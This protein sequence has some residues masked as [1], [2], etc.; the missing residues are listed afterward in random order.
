MSSTA[1]PGSV[2]SSP[3]KWG[4][5]SSS[6]SSLSAS[7]P[8]RSARNSAVAA[9]AAGSEAGLSAE[10]AISSAIAAACQSLGR[11]PGPAEAALVERLEENWFQ[12]AADLA[13]ISDADAA[14]L[15]LPLRL[16]SQVVLLLHRRQQQQQQVSAQA[17]MGQV[18]DVE[19]AGE[20]TAGGAAPD[21]KWT[22]PEA[23][24]LLVS[25]YLS[26]HGHIPLPGTGSGAAVQTGSSSEKQAA[27]AVSSSTSSR[28]NKGRGKLQQAA[29]GGS[30]STEGS[31]GHRHGGGGSSE[32]GEVA[33][34]S[35]VEEEDEEV[36][37]ASVPVEDRRCPPV[38]RMEFAAADAPRLT[39]AG[40]RAPY[41]LKEAEMS[42]ALR[43]EFQ[44]FNRFCTVRFFGQQADP[45]LPV[46]AAKY[47]DHMRL[48]LGW[49]HRYQGQPLATL[50]FSSCLPSAKR[51]G[52][53]VAF[54]YLQWLVSE[55]GIGVRT[56]RMAL[57]AIQQA[58]KFLYHEESKVRAGSGDRA[59][60]DV[61][62]IKEL[63]LLDNTARRQEKVA[64]RRTGL[65]DAQ[66]GVD[67]PVEDPGGLE[68]WVD[69]ALKWLDWLE[70]LAV[71]QEL[72]RECA[73]RD[74]LGRVR[75]PASVA[76]SLQ[77]YLMFAILSCVPD[78]QRTLRELEVGRS[79]VQEKGRWLIRHGPADYK[80]GRA[81]GERPPL[82]IAPHIYPEL[83][84]FIAKWRAEL[85]PHHNLLFSQ[86]NG[87]PMTQQAVHKV[88]TT[89][90]YR[91]TGKKCNP[92]LIRDSVVTYLRGAGASERELEALAIYMGH[93][94]EMQRGTYDR[95]TKQQKV[96]PAV[97]LLESLNSRVVGGGARGG[98]QGS[99][100]AAAGGSAA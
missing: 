65:M 1:P 83:E 6:R 76:W 5:L 78:R 79:L 28:R 42:E 69:E 30:G 49:L 26:G 31:G 27:A 89:T 24:E 14:S 32:P 98:G 90:A 67:D 8:T 53:T 7:G 43:D 86:K 55:R 36:D 17:A 29:T 2:H 68:L 58:A 94:V 62:L 34:A 64:P 48:F 66:A 56:E 12:T 54:D 57:R 18:T 80:T 50:S 81:Y 75:S 22:L 11:V 84:A 61:D 73:G 39:K 77:R 72:R 44:R 46:T 51:E 52:V 20:A 23:A 97:E 38:R 88:F 74:S 21:G 33:E 93:S 40:K 45:I 87:Q 47:A 16:R 15:K 19:P 60:S 85:Q 96:E 35:R 3:P 92:H 99:G 63:R 100:P 82:V 41:A 70:Y 91:L 9:S 13:E 59:Y 37:L 71:V 95:R 4:R 25:E 10:A